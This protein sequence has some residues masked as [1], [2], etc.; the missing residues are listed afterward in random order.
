MVVG[1]ERSHYALISSQ[2]LTISV[3]VDGIADV[4]VFATA[5]AVFTATAVTVAVVAVAVVA[6]S[7]AAV[8][9]ATAAVAAVAAAVAVSKFVD[10][11]LPLQSM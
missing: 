4:T 11:T 3:E 5:A 6:V 1:L 9:A 2:F 7:A 8:V 10:L